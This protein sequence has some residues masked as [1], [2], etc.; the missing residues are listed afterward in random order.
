MVAVAE[1][2]GGAGVVD[3]C[4]PL[5]VDDVGVSL[6]PNVDAGVPLPPGVGV[7]REPGV[8]IGVSRPP[9]VGVFRP[10]A[11]GV[12]VGVPAVGVGVGVPC[13][14]GGNEMT[15]GASAPHAWSVVPAVGR[16][17]SMG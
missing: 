12:G 10:P 8:G 4:R 11:V 13:P 16:G 3:V 1:P 17:V 14:T 15:E 5:G 7:P 6:S 2:E 9:G